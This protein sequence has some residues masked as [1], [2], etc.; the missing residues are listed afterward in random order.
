VSSKALMFL[1]GVFFFPI[2]LVNISVTGH[3]FLNLEFLQFGGM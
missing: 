1:D 3:Y 2:F